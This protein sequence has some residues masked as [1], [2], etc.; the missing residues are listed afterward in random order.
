MFVGYV[1]GTD[2]AAH[3]FRV[4][5]YECLG[6]WHIDRLEDGL[7]VPVKGSS[8]LDDLV[9]AVHLD[10]GNDFKSQCLCDL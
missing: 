1:R 8:L 6:R 2:T 10:G 5:G 3:H 4:S 7:Y 9:V